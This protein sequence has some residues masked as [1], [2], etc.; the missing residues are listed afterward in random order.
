MHRTAGTKANSRAK[1]IESGPGNDALGYG[2]LMLSEPFS[3]EIGSVGRK[4]GRE[5]G[6]L[7]ASSDSTVT[8]V[9]IIALR[10]V[11]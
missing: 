9:S 11:S 4:M 7:R 8:T 10:V 3:H 1:E 6:F 2:L 5:V